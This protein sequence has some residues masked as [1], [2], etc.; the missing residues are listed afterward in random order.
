MAISLTLHAWHH[1]TPVKLAWI[2]AS[3]KS[4]IPLNLVKIV[5]HM[6]LSNETSRV[7]EAV[8]GGRGRSCKPRREHYV[9]S[10]LQALG[11]HLAFL[12]HQTKFF[13][14]KCTA[15]LAPGICVRIWEIEAGF[16]PEVR[17]VKLLSFWLLRFF[18]LSS[19]SSLQSNVEPW[20]RNTNLIYC[21]MVIYM[22]NWAF[23]AT[24]CKCTIWAFNRRARESRPYWESE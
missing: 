19:K 16:L 10:G 21:I 6:F 15:C 18:V 20:V 17:K 24:S 22:H 3:P 8:G 1:L 5:F 12:F 13:V 23:H 2:N 9:L 14:R 7:Q 11:S 4:R